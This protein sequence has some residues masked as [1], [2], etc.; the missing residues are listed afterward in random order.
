MGNLSNTNKQDV[1]Q[2]TII[3]YVFKPKINWYKNVFWSKFG[4][5]NK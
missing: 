5:N 1:R 2:E 3:T 4:H